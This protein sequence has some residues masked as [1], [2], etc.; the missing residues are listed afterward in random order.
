MYKIAKDNLPKLY[1]ALQNIGMLLLPCKNKSGHADF[2]PYREDAVVA[3]DAPLTNRSAKDVFFPQVENLLTFKTSGKELALEQNVPPADVTIVMGVRAC[4]ARSF[5]ILDKV[6]LKAPVDTYYKT[7]RE[8]CVLIGLGCSAP[9]ETC[10]C[11]AFGIDAGA[12]ETDV[13]T[14]L[15]GEELCWQA[16]TAKGEELTAK[17]VSA[18]VLAE[19]DAD[20]AAAVSEQQEQTQKI[21]SV[22]P[23]HDFKVN[24]ELTKDELKAFHS[25]IWEQ[26]AAGCLSCCTCT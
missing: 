23:L 3:M 9:E 13:Q 6:F 24:D 20:A 11:H 2:A 1:D 12:P 7:R 19:A 8:Q 21:L 18:G 4:D 25:K 22:L 17:L 26:L 5:K 15:V 14:W 10:F 16:V